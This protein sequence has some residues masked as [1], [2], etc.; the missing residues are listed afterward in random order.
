MKGHDLFDPEQY[1]RI[2]AVER[3]DA[4]LRFQKADLSKWIFL[5]EITRGTLLVLHF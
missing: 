4:R 2:R 1:S 3:A 5:K